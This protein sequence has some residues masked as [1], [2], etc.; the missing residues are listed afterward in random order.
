[1]IR[2]E[3]TLL[4]W[5]SG[6]HQLQD[7]MLRFEQRIRFCKSRDGT[8]IAVATLGRG[9][10]L[11]RTA[12]WLS[13][14]EHDA[15]SPVWTHWL[16][17]LSRDHT[18][19][20]YDQRGCGLSDWSPPC[21]SFEAWID[22]LDAIVEAQGLK[23]FSLFGMSQ[24]GAIAIAYAARHPEKVSR[25]VLFGAYAKGA[26]RRDITESQREEAETL[27]KLI[28]LGWGR[29]NPAFRQVFTSQFIPG[30]TR[31]QHQWFNDLERT[32]TSPQNAAAI[33]EMLYQIDVTADAER[34]CVPTLVMHALDDERVPFEEGRQLAALI[35]SARFV[36]LESRN[37]VLL[38]DEPA[39]PQF[40]Q[41]FR[42]F[43]SNAGS[44]PGS[45][46]QSG[47]TTSEHEVLALVAR[48]LDNGTIADALAKSEKT[49]R[50]QVSSIFNKLGVRTRAQAIV[51]ARDAGIGGAA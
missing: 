2:G 46:R 30:G 47:L 4:L 24:G 36:P 26:L 11:L 39:W 29:D 9:P 25:L 17:E 48:G 5:A 45:L 34:I 28:R 22:D 15:R 41:E 13:H 18:F 42:A 31:D 51:L 16:E 10:P 20:R 38:A 35:P 50:N 6:R 40:L 14:A 49:V 8:R 12:H 37:H 32:T 1:M 27:V 21:T 33:V 7:V 19:I 44:T 23:Q 3:A 43:V